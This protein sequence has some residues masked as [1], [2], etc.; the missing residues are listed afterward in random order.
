[1]NDQATRLGIIALALVVGA[2]YF[3]YRKI[4]GDAYDRGYQEGYSTGYDDKAD[5]MRPILE[6]AIF[7]QQEMLSD[8]YSLQDEYNNLRHNVSG[9]LASIGQRVPYMSR[10][11]CVTKTAISYEYKGCY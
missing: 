10:L 4:T 9:Y 6:D 2:L 8:F 11:E 7:Q 3:G 5:D 1:M